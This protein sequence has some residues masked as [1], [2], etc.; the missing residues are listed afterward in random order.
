MTRQARLF[1]ATA[2]A[3]LCLA[4]NA[5][6][7]GQGQGH[8]YGHSRTDAAKAY[9]RLCQ[10]E[11]KQH[12]LGQQG[13]PFSDCVNDMAQLASGARSNPHRACANESKKHVAGQKGTPYSQCVSAAAKLQ[14]NH[15]DDSTNTDS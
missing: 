2:A 8:A 13:T 14:R 10:G 6:G 1:A 12:V 5:L 7:Q 11:S 4:P 3:A 15:G 9:G